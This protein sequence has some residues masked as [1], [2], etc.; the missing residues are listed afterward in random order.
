MGNLK[1]ALTAIFNAHG[2][3]DFSSTSKVPYFNSSNNPYG[4]ATPAKLASVLGGLPLGLAPNSVFENASSGPTFTIRKGEHQ[5]V[6][7][8]ATNGPANI[9]TVVLLPRKDTSSI[10]TIHQGSFPVSNITLDSSTGDITISKG[11]SHFWYWLLD[12]ERI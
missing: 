5:A 3:N 4:M 8:C 11:T 10:V 2:D 9:P 1:A 6:F 7:V 12:M